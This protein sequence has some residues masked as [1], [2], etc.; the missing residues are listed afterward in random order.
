MESQ[1]VGITPEHI[2]MRRRLARFISF[3]EL[4]L[5]YLMFKSSDML[6]P[7]VKYS[8]FRQPSWVPCVLR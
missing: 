7:I 3:T 6:L 5:L 2:N 4:K 1:N 8:E